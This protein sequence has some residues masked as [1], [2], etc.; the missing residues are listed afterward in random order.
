MRRSFWCCCYVE[1]DDEESVSINTSGASQSVYASMDSLPEPM[2]TDAQQKG[3]MEAFDQYIHQEL[4]NFL[5]SDD[6]RV[7]CILSYFTAGEYAPQ[8]QLNKQGTHYD[9][10]LKYQ[11]FFIDSFNQYM[12][13]FAESL[14]GILHSTPHK[15]DQGVKYSCNVLSVGKQAASA[16]LEMNREQQMPQFRVFSAI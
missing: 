8:M 15:F 12:G 11:G 14:E 9:L 10:P 1:C 7:S 13:Q 2:A 16:L 3:E 5:E 6:P 4:I